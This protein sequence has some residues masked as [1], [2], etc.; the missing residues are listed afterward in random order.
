MSN[1][2]RIKITTR[3]V[4][5]IEKKTT[6]TEARAKKKTAVKGDKTLKASVKARGEK[7][8][9]KE[10]TKPAAPRRS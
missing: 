7:R 9:Q 2:K 1:A 8:Q 3:D 6:I 5:R 10:N 4:K